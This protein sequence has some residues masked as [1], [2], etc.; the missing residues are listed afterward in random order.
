MPYLGITLGFRLGLQKSVKPLPFLSLFLISCCAS[1]RAEEE[2]VKPELLP[3]FPSWARVGVSPVLSQE[4]PCHQSQALCKGTA[5][6]LLPDPGGIWIQPCTVLLSP[7]S[8][9]LSGY[10]FSLSRSKQSIGATENSLNIPSSFPLGKGFVWTGLCSPCSWEISI[11]PDPSKV[12]ACPLLE[13]LPSRWGLLAWG[14]EFRISFQSL[15][16]IDFS[17]NIRLATQSNGIF[18]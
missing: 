10:R 18:D 1:G 13:P 11:A 15:C 6:L 8:P 3:P 2:L 4:C 9:L 14:K 5:L 12:W 17:M 7:L 16:G